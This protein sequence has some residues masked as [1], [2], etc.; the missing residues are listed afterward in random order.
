MGR[1]DQNS[2][3]VGQPATEGARR[4]GARQVRRGL[5]LGQGEE[6][7]CMRKKN[8]AGIRREGRVHRSLPKSA[9]WTR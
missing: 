2:G 1:P 5:R 3:G 8:E 7:S 4:Q 6:G 9:L